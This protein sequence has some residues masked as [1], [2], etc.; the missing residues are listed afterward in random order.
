MTKPPRLLT[1]DEFRN[2]VF[3]RDGHNCVICKAA[4]KDAHH[5]LERRLFPDGGY[6]L[7]NGA[8]VCEEHHIAA[9]QTTLSCEEIR[10]A[11]GITQVVLPPHLYPD[12]RYD[13]WGNPILPN[14]QRLRGELFD[15]ESVQKILQVVLSVFTNKVKYPRTWH[16]PFSPGVGPDDRV[17]QDLSV[18][19][20]QEIVI[21][22]K[23]DGENTTFY[24]DYIHARSTD[25]SAHPS[26]GWV[27][28]FHAKIQHDIPD[29][30]RVC[31]ENL[32]AK[33]SIGYDSLPTYFMGFS[34]WTDANMC[35]SWDETLEW[36]SMLG[37]VPVP[38]LF[39]G[40]W[41]DK[42]IT[43]LYESLDPSKN[44]GFVVRVTDKFHYKD[45]RTRIAKYVR[46][47]HV[48]THGHWMRQAVERNVLVMEKT[49]D[50]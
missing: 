24:N 8:T 32:F 39:R 41:D 37:V 43:K 20:S 19:R 4:G 25:Y 35:L 26:R 30:W 33:H 29:G 5:I 9:E 6:Y 22:E 11:A 17:I 34:V 16:L 38:T 10:E 1:R 48:Q 3:D 45:F 23:M 40:R 50:Q 13:K 49:D 28:A 46:A 15:D 36:F 14:G 18:L 12:Q 42:A 31:G 21:T 27:R 47:S 44:E 7:N 2:S